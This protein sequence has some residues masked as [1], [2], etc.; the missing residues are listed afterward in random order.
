MWLKAVLVVSLFCGSVVLGSGWQVLDFE[1]AFPQS[2]VEQ[3]MRNLAHIRAGLDHVDSANSEAVQQ[4][5]I[6]KLQ[7]I[8]KIV[9]QLQAEWVWPDDLSYLG[10]LLQSLQ[11][12]FEQFLT[13]LTP[14]A[15][16]A[17]QLFKKAQAD[18]ATLTMPS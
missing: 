12:R 14:V 3:L 2:K 11:Q 17:I 16:L 10:R 9:G 15:E 8:I 18:L 5:I 6:Q 7:D 13:G 1:Q 4:V